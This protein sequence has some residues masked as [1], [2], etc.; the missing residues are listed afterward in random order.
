MKVLLLLFFAFISPLVIFLTTVLY[1]G[2]SP[3]ILK[4]ELAEANIY[5]KVTAFLTN[6]SDE[7]EE[8]T[9]I[10]DIVAANFTPEYTQSKV[11]DVIDTSYDWITGETT[12]SPSVSFPEIKQQILTQH[13]SLLTDIEAMAK[14]AEQTF[15]T[16][17]MSEEEAVQAE[18]MHTQMTSQMGMMTEFVKND[19]SWPLTK[20]LTGVKQ[21]YSVIKLLQPILTLLLLLSL[22]I[23]GLL[24]PTW[25]QRLKW[26]GA[27][28][29]VAGIAG[30]M[31]VAFQAGI[32]ALL[33][34]VTQQ[35][36]NEAVTMFTP[37]IISIVR[38]FVKTYTN[39]Q[40]I[41]SIVFFVVAALCFVIASLHKNEKP[42]LKPVTV[43]TKKK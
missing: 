1:G 10:T 37:I 16:T 43:K 6:T 5:S 23:L 9:E 17:G 22:L 14:D 41:V 3:D 7:G 2:T 35:T 33:T 21:L 8:N 36:T 24:N 31:A 42:A 11:E 13:P 4:T 12:Q 28:L 30:F 29:F 20:Q 32:V 26:T 38:H 39:Y 19:F 34:T 15:D 40:G 25:P 18:Q 27:A